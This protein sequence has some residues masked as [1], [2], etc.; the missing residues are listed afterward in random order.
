[1]FLFSVSVSII[2]SNLNHSGAREMYE[3]KFKEVRRMAQNF[4]KGFV[5]E[6]IKNIVRQ[7]FSRE[8][9]FYEF[10]KQRLTLQLDTL[11]NNRRIE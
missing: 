2:P 6:E 1:M 4:H 5:S 9:E 7:N 11:R 10:C 8:M 3:K